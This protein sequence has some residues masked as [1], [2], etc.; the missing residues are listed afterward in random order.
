MYGELTDKLEKDKNQF[1]EMK[2]LL[3]QLKKAK[4]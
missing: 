3:S 1:T 2:K 4:E